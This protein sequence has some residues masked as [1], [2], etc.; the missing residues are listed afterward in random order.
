[1]QCSIPST[2]K[3]NKIAQTFRPRTIQRIKLADFISVAR[4]RPRTSKGIT[5][6]THVTGRRQGLGFLDLFPVARSPEGLART[7][8]RG[9]LGRHLGVRCDGSP[10][11][12]S[13]QDWPRPHSFGL[14]A[15]PVPGCLAQ[16]NGPGRSVSKNRRLLHTDECF[17]LMK[18]LEGPC[19][20][21]T[22]P[23][24]QAM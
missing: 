17:A 19:S 12:S 3:F 8:S 5:A 18:S 9:N 16:T 21:P 7:S 6:V 23:L 2:I 14:P 22:I 13:P 10:L 24:L 20:D 11:R 15:S 4:V 1:M